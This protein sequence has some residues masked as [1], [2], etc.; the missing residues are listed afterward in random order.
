MHQAGRVV[1]GREDWLSCY[2]GEVRAEGGMNFEPVGHLLN[3]AVG[4]ITVAVALLTFGS[5]E[6]GLC[7]RPRFSLLTLLIATTAIAVF[8][9]SVAATRR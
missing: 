1:I 3:I 6:V 9:G 2:D 5:L 7:Q 4:I 8:L